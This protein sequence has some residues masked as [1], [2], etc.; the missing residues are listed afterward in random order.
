MRVYLA[1]PMVGCDDKEIFG[2]RN[3]VTEGLND[4]QWD[5]CDP[6]IGTEYLVQ[7]GMRMLMDN[8][9][10]GITNAE[11]FYKDIYQIRKS[12]VLLVNLEHANGLST[13]YA[14]EMGLAYERG[15]MVIVVNAGVRGNHPFIDIPAIQLDTVEQAI[16]FLKELH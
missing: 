10:Q 14:F 3:E 6:T 16:E 2:W 15:M 13:G 8:A 5:V 1:G 7:N 12:D 11:V 4:T 9:A